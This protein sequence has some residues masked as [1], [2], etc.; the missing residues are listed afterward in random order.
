MSRTAS[1]PLRCACG[2]PTSTPK[3]RQCRPCA[4]QSAKEYRARKAAERTALES[5]AATPPDARA[6]A[7][8]SFAEHIRRLVAS[9]R[10]RPVPRVVHVSKLA[11][12]LAR[13]DHPEPP[14]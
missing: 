9:V 7:L 4:A 3:S 11:D 6:E 1:E 8:E 13:L 10:V 14:A 5:A 12:A 2:A